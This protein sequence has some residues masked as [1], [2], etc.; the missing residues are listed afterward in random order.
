MERSVL[1]FVS[2]LVFSAPAWC[3]GL[4]TINGSVTD[5]SGAVIARANISVSEVDTSLQRSTLTSAEGLYVISGL[6]PTRYTL[7]AA[8]PGF[9]QVTQTGIVLEANDT[10]TINLLGG[11]TRTSGP[12]ANQAPCVTYLVPTSFAAPAL[13]TYGN[14]AKGALRGPGLFNTDWG[15]FKNFSVTERVKVQFRAE[16]FDIFNRVN[17]SNPG[18]SA[19]SGSFGNILGARDPRIGQL[20]LKVLF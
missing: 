6:H 18:T 20:A 8:A 5:P 4:S 9:R 11:S 2:L 15:I 13:G 7:T 1:A 16:F 14:V 19:N 10:L 3:Q 12:C 17:F